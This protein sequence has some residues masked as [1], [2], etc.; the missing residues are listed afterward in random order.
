M[1]HILS[2]LLNTEKLLCCMYIIR[3]EFVQC[4]YQSLL[5]ITDDINGRFHQNSDGRQVTGVFD[6]KLINYP[7]DLEYC[8]IYLVNSI[9]S[10][11]LQCCEHQI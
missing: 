4:D 10:V 3:M 6:Y 7:L 9:N 8:L 5:A 11:H 2:D 1:Y